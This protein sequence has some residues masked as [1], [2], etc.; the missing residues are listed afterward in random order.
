MCIILQTIANKC[1]GNVQFHCKEGAHNIA[2]AR[3]AI[4]N[5][6]MT[7]LA[8]GKDKKCFYDDI[9]RRVMQQMPVSKCNG[10]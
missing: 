6:L 2:I 4:N 5:V 8:P 1:M 9:K 3:G 10:N 7:F